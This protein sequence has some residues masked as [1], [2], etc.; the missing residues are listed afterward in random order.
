MTTVTGGLPPKPPPVPTL[1]QVV[2]YLLPGVAKAAPIHRA[3]FVTEVETAPSAPPLVN[4]CVFHTT[5]FAFVYGVAYGTESGQWSWP[6][7]K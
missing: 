2:W 1:G 7:A 5:G 4:L 3:A 6:P